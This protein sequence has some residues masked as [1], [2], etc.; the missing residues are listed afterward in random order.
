[1]FVEVIFN[2]LMNA[3]HSRFVSTSDRHALILHLRDRGMEPWRMAAKA[4]GVERIGSISQPSGKIDIPQGAIIS[5][6][7][8]SSE[9]IKQFVLL[10]GGY[11]DENTEPD[12]SGYYTA[13]IAIESIDAGSKYNVSA[14]VINTFVTDIPGID[15]CYNPADT[16]YARDEETIEEV[17]E[18]IFDRNLSKTEKTMTWFVSETKENFDFVVD[19]VCI[20]RYKG[21]GTVG[22]AIRTASG[23]PSPEQLSSIEAHFNTDERDPAGA[24]HVYATSVTS[25]IWNATIKVYWTDSEPTDETLNTYVR[26]YFK[27]LGRG[28]PIFRVWITTILLSNVAGLKN[29]EIISSSGE[30]VPAQSYPVLGT[31]TWVKEQYGQV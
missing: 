20:P 23:L 19:A 27:D 17:K 11:I 16:A 2:D 31:V 18:R 6:P 10:N 3:Y 26:N 25:Y 1:M 7:G 8:D 28:E 4:R 14:G 29:A 22:I 13:E 30:V 21:R 24:Y 12:E 9:T 15:V 5:T